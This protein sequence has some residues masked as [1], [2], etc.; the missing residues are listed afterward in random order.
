MMSAVSSLDIYAHNSS[1][2][3]HHDL[4][5]IA[6]AVICLDLDIYPLKN[7]ADLLQTLPGEE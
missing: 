3:L 5:K 7:T 1:K 2:A 4:E 6:A